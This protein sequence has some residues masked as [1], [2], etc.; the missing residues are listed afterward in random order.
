MFIKI[1]SFLKKKKVWLPYTCK[2][3]FTFEK[4]EN[5]SRVV[6]D[7]VIYTFGNIETNERTHDPGDPSRV[8]SRDLT[9][10]GQDLDYTPEG[11]SEI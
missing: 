8:Y 11:T 9:R 7:N 1:R 4:V 10:D 3:Y 2:Y 5:L 6:D